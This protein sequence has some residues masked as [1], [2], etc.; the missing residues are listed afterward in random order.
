MTAPQR[1]ML[2]QVLRS[3]PF[4]LGGGDVAIQRP[5]LEPMLTSHPRAHLLL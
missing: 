3:A 4:D 1:D 2:D 5:V